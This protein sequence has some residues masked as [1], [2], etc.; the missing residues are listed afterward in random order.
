[1]IETLVMSILMAI[2]ILIDFKTGREKVSIETTK[3]SKTANELGDD[4]PL[5]LGDVTQIIDR[6]FNEHG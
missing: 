1:M 6:K 5:K 3:G 4:Q 2:M